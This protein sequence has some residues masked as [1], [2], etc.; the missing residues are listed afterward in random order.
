MCNQTFNRLCNEWTANRYNDITTEICND[1]GI[2]LDGFP[3]G[4]VMQEVRRLSKAKGLWFQDI[5]ES[6]IYIEL[7]PFGGYTTET[8]KT[9]KEALQ[10]YRKSGG[11]N[12]VYREILGEQ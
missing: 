10:R 9:L 11:K 1:L 7:M 12:S 5:C 2:S 4:K 6:D 8:L 3:S